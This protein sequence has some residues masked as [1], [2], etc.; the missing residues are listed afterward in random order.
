MHTHLGRSPWASVG[1]DD[2]PFRA[3]EVDRE[4]GTIVWP[5]EVDLDPDVLR[6]DQQLAA[7]TALP[8][9]VILNA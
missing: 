9:R 3:V 4:F 1:D 8:R 2:E 5:G 6:G 7:G